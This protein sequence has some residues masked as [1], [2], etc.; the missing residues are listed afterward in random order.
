MP[1]YSRSHLERTRRERYSSRVEILV[2][3]LNA[4][5]FINREIPSFIFTYLR[6]SEDENSGYRSISID[7]RLCWVIIV[8]PE[9]LRVRLSYS[10]SRWSSQF[11]FINFRLRGSV[12]LKTKLHRVNCSFHNRSSIMVAEGA[13]W[14]R[15]SSASVARYGKFALESGRNS[16]GLYRPYRVS[17]QWWLTPRGIVRNKTRTT[18]ENVRSTR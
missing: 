12:A 6:I 15:E 17:G 4:L 7:Y 14:A 8:K 11:R 1:K 3:F 16:K 9:V 10:C 18:G 2:R 13:N 5:V